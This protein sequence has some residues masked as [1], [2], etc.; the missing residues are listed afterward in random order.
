MR[1]T[2]C[3]T[4]VSIRVC[5]HMLIHSQ[6]RKNLDSKTRRCVFIRY[7]DETKGYKVFDPL[8]K[9]MKVSQNMCFFEDTPWDWSKPLGVEPEFVT[10]NMQA[11]IPSTGASQSQT[12]N[13][14]LESETE[15]SS[16][17]EKSPTQ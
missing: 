11:G 12:Q 9:K 6:F 7:S 5:A 17:P 14:T 4:L 13:S 1:E 16:L 10:I 3:E 2:I 15:A 8:N